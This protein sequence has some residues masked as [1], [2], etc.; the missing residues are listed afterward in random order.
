[1]TGYNVLVIGRPS[2]NG[3]LDTINEYLPQKFVDQ[4]DALEQMVG[5]VAYQVPPG[6]SLGVM[7]VITSPF[8]PTMG[9]TLVSGTNDE[10]Q[11]FVYDRLVQNPLNLVELEGDLV[12]FGNKT[13]K[14]LTTF[15]GVPVALDIASSSVT[16]TQVALQAVPTGG[17]NA[18]QTDKTEVPKYVST[19]T[20]E[21]PVSQ[22][23][24]KYLLIGLIASGSFILLLAVIRTARGGRRS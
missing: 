13:V 4:T 24:G 1:M 3:L 9:L 16:G 6:V 22:M 17:V 7:E 8:D 18:T 12:F 23:L 15:E 11:R 19:V 20:V 5:N 21:N 2:T 14:A 10:G